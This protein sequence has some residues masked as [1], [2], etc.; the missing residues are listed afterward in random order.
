MAVAA[1]YVVGLAVAGRIRI[2]VGS[3][4]TVPTQAV[5]VPLLFAVPLPF[6]PLLVALSLA[7]GMTPGVLRGRVRRAGC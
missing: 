4:F 3:G 6:V 5:F 2:D 7:L 1:L